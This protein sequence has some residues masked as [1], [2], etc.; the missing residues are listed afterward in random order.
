MS[1]KTVSLSSFTP[2]STPT[3]VDNTLIDGFVDGRPVVIRKMRDG[4]MMPAIGTIVTMPYGTGIVSG[5][6]DDML[7]VDVV[8]FNESF[9]FETKDIENPDILD[10]SEYVDSLNR[11][12]RRSVESFRS[13]FQRLYKSEIT[14]NLSERNEQRMW[15]AFPMP[16]TDTE[17][18]IAFT[19]DY[20]APTD[21]IVVREV[22][23]QR[24]T[25]SERRARIKAEQA[26]AKRLADAMLDD[27][28]ETDIP[29]DVM[30]EIA[31]AFGE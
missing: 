10:A 30:A 17:I 31:D 5:Y 19:G 13:D 12:Y 21:H 22:T 6:R 20:L 15:S 8:E 24:E 3:I 29:E 7:V 27:A 9:E 14:G 28:D 2:V 25:P 18:V 23:K 26:H 1:Y 4:M 16:S 11:C